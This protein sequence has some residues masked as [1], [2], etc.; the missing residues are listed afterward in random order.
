MS[1]AGVGA[2]WAGYFTVIVS[3]SDFFVL[4]CREID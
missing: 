1:V 4:K 3:L 2:D